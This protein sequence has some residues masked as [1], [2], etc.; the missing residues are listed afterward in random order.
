M[1]HH[2]IPTLLLREGA[3]TSIGRRE[4]LGRSDTARATKGGTDVRRQTNVPRGDLS[5]LDGPIIVLPGSTEVA[6]AEA[7][8]HR[9]R[10]LVIA[11]GGV[12]TRALAT[13]VSATRAEDVAVHVVVPIGHAAATPG[14][15]LRGEYLVQPVPDDVRWAFARC[16]I[17]QVLRRL[18][19][20]GVAATGDV[21]TTPPSRMVRD[22]VLER[23]VDEILLTV[24][25]NPWARRR[26]TQLAHRLADDA[27]VP[28]VIE[29]V[30]A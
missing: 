6:R 30:D 11:L 7:H 12:D 20:L 22:H 23:D 29:T 25:P 21:V 17:E 1:Y 8:V 5:S 14:P 9:Y 28:V 4:P 15:L 10:A 27:G 3:V 18:R 26:A 13:R 19:A 16:S 2:G 24:R